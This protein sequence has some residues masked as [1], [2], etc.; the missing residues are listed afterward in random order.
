MEIWFKKMEI[1]EKKF[2]IFEKLVVEGSFCRIDWSL[3]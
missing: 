1:L 2:E 3:C